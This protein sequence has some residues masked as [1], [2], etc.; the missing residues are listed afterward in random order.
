MNNFQKS[1]KDQQD[2]SSAERLL[3][4]AE[5]CDEPLKSELKALAAKFTANDKD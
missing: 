1:M 2:S 3:T 5:G 4:M